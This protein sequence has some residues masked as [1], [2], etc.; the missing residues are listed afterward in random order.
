MPEKIMKVRWSEGASLSQSRKQPGDYSPLT[1]DADTKELGQVTLSDIDEAEFNPS[2]VYVFD[3]QE[4]EE[5]DED[6]ET[7]AVAALVI[8]GVIIAVAKASPHVREWLQTTAVPAM[9]ESRDRFARAIRRGNRPRDT[10]IAVVVE[11]A[12]STSS[13]V[14]T[15]L[16]DAPTVSMSSAEWEER[17]RLMLL[18]GAVQDEQWRLLSTARVVDRGDLVEVQKAMGG[19][20]AQQ[21]AEGIKLALES[22]H[23]LLDAETSAAM[24]RVFAGIRVDDGTK[25]IGGQTQ[26]ERGELR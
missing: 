24:T 15:A 20:S 4:A 1:R 23:S 5:R 17:F 6:A 9:K 13:E 7:V 22:N 10:E 25:K 11:P 12:P 2:P 8:L 14:G 18:A 16:A 26:S 21:V 19:L 3:N